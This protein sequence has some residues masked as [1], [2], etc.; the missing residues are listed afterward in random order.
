MPL[1][2]IRLN[3]IG[4]DGSGVSAAELTREIIKPLLASVVK[5]VTENATKLGLDLKNL[6]A[7]SLNQIK[8]AGKGT[9]QD[10][11]KTTKDV[12]DLFK[13]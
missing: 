5:A 8:D 1:P 11:E 9:L 2:D 3:N 13:K 7:D 6:G 12:K 4:S 10:L